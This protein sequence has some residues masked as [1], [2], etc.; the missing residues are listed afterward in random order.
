LTQVGEKLWDVLKIKA[1]D[2][3]PS[4]KCGEFLCRLATVI[5]SRSRLF[6]AAYTARERERESVLFCPERLVRLTT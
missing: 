4:L 3:W 2:A 1:C 5:F 6:H